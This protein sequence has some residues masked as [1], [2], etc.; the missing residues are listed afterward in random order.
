MLTTLDVTG[1][2]YGV[3]YCPCWWFKLLPG[4]GHG[5]L[6]EDSNEPYHDQRSV[7]IDF[8]PRYFA[9][10]HIYML[11]WGP[12]H[13]SRRI[14]LHHFCNFQTV[15]NDRYVDEEQHAC[16]KLTPT[17]LQERQIFLTACS[18][19]DMD[20]IPETFVVDFGNHFSGENNHTDLT[21]QLP[22]LWWKITKFKLH[23]IPNQQ[24][25]WQI[26]FLDNFQRFLECSA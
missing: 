14:G 4:F 19:C 10:M 25:M 13:P 26:S 17:V 8:S 12:K 22:W 6:Q 21:V 11:P 24:Q 9:D 18:F 5:K 20:G 3:T 15:Q 2:Y 23:H 1:N 16:I 7:K